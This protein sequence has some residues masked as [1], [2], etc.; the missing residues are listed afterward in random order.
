MD[1][2]ILLITYREQG[3][4]EGYVNNMIAFDKWLD[5]HNRERRKEG[6]SL[7]HKNEFE[8]KEIEKLW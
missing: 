5:T 6:E 3:T 7:E 4:I 8:I 1:N 2:K